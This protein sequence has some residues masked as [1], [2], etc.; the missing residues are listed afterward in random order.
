MNETIKA[1]ILEVSI[2]VEGKKKLTCKQ[3]FQIASDLNVSLKE[4]GNCCNDN[5]IK[6]FSCQLGCF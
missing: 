5:D 4:V 6:L 2:E 1:K 3:A